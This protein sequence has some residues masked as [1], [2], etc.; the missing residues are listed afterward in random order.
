[1]LT[2][3]AIKNFKS[4]GDPGIDLELRPLTFLVGKNGSGKSSVLEALALLAQSVD[5]GNTLWIGNLVKYDDP[6][7]VVHQRDTE[8]SIAI[9]LDMVTQDTQPLSLKYEIA[10]REGRYHNHLMNS[11]SEQGMARVSSAIKNRAF[12]LR[13]V[14]GTEMGE[15]Q[16]RKPPLEWVGPQGEYLLH[17]LSVIFGPEGNQE[18][19]SNIK[20]WAEIFEVDE[21]ISGFT[22]TGNLGASYRDTKTGTKLPASSTSYGSRQVLPIIVQ[23][24]WSEPGSIIMI[25]EPEISLHPQ[26]QVDI[27][28]LLATAASDGKQILATTH[29][30]FLLMGLTSA[31][32]KK[33]I[34]PQD[35]VVYE[36]EKGTKGTKVRKKLEMN[37]RGVIKGWVDSFSEVDKRLFQEWSDTLPRV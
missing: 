30:T 21:L 23:I 29:S 37:K 4:I 25:E 33:I 5:L 19:G 1:M 27:A 16:P 28:E 13:S 14:R 22:K 20:R 17:V 34:K 35:V 26:A 15:M 7:D 6:L 2:R 8:G 10:F 11:A 12:L 31:V 24:F 3:L 9:V 36:L 18:I 32:K